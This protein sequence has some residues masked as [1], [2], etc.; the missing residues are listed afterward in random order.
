MRRINDLTGCQGFSTHWLAVSSDQ[1]LL[2]FLP[3]PLIQKK[4][5]QLVIQVRLP[6]S[7][8]WEEESASQGSTDCLAVSPNPPGWFHSGS[9]TPI[10]G[11]VQ[12]Q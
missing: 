3:L 12:K 9:F 1:E 11:W 6:S 4:Q 8:G 2:C 5:S 10:M 7:K